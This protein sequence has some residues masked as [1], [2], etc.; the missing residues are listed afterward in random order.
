VVEVPRAVG[1]VE[2]ESVDLDE[3]VVG[4]VEPFVV[5]AVAS[6]AQGVGEA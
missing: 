6:A 5:D 2:V 1:V 4:P 3:Q